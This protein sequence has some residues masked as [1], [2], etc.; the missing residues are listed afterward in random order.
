MKKLFGCTLTAMGVMAG[1]ALAAN[2]DSPAPPSDA[3]SAMPTINGIYDRLATGAPSPARTGAFTE[4]NAAPS[5]SS[6]TLTEVLAKAPAADTINGALSSDVKAGK[7]YWSLRTDSTWGLQAGTSPAAKVPETGQASCYDA[8]GTVISCAGTGQDG[9]LKPGEAWPNPRFTDNNNGTI[10]DNLTGLIWLK[11][12]NCLETVGGISKSLGT[13]T[14]TNALTWSNSLTTGKCGLTDNSLAGVWRLPSR[15]ELLSLVDL[16][17]SSPALANKA[18]TGHWASGD[19]FVGVQTSSY[20]SSSTS[21][22]SPTAAWAV[23]LSNG[24]V[25]FSGNTKANSNYVWP[26][27]GGD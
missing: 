2:L 17:Y 9:A 3:T 1:A 8:S 26:V 22:A 16:Q 23:D 19:P 15:S 7:T 11:N 4:P 18:G 20:W 6:H 14:W 10:T 25:T 21:V 13:L 5:S 12:S 24:S 27:R